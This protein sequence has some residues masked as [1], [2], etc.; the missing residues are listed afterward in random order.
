MVR[1]P[2]LLVCLAAALAGCSPEAAAYRHPFN[3]LVVEL[4]LVGFSGYYPCSFVTAE[5]GFEAIHSLDSEDC[6]RFDRPRRMRGVWLLANETSQL[7]PD[8]TRSPVV[9]DIM[10]ENQTFLEPEKWEATEALP[11]PIRSSLSAAVHA[12]PASTE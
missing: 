12:I 10:D 3:R 5:N 2:L 6:Y 4:G 7:L 11:P 1:R 8:A 9:W